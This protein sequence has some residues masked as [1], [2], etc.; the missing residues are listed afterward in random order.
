MKAPGED[1]AKA[2]QDAQDFVGQKRADAQ[3]AQGRTA[4]NTSQIS[5]R[6]LS[7]AGEA[8]HTATDSTSPAHVDANGNPRD[9]GRIPVVGSGSIH[10][11][12]VHIAEEAN[13]TPTQ[14]DNAV[15]A[16]QDQFIK[17]FG[18][19]PVCVQ[20]TGSEAACHC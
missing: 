7:A 18:S 12:E 20:A 1:P 14:F 11:A 8:I 4:E 10:D 19:G 6:A 3:S 13:P 16:A 17:V 2:K 5:D 15:K 9:W